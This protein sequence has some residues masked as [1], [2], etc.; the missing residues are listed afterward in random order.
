MSHAQRRLWFLEHVG[1]GGTAYHLAAGVRLTGPLNVPALDTALADV[2]ERH[3]PLRTV[4][5]DEPGQEILE[6]FR[7]EL[8]VTSVSESRLDAAVRAATAAPFRIDERPPFRAALFRLGPEEH[9]LVLM[10]HH[11]AVDGWSVPILMRDLGTAYR[12]R[13]V[14]L[15]GPGWDELPVRY[16]DYTLWQRDL[17]G[18]PADP[19]SL[20][21]RQ[22]D[23]WRR[24]LAGL[25]DAPAL[26]TDR[27]RPATAR[28]HGARTPVTCDPERYRDLVRLA[29]EHHCTPFMAVHALLAVLLSRLGASDDTVLGAAV[30]GRTEEPMAD[31]VG[32]FV[33]TLVLRTNLSD[34][35]SFRQVLDRVRQTDLDAYAHQD[36]PFDL[37]VEAL[38]PSRSLAHHPLF[39]VLLAFES[40]GPEQPDFGVVRAARLPVDGPPAAKVDLTFQLVEEQAEDGTPLHLTGY[41]EYD[42]DLFEADTA[43]AIPARLD[44]LLGAVVTDPDRPVAEIDLRTPQER[45]L[46]T[47]AD[48]PRRPVTTLPQSLAD[49]AA[50]TPDAPA[51]VC[52]DTTLTHAD[53]HTR[54]DRLAHRLTASGAAPG[55]IVAVALPRSVDFVV[56]ILAVLKAGCAYLPVD[57]ELPTARVDDMLAEA[58]P[59]CVLT[60]DGML[61]WDSDQGAAS[62]PRPEHPAYVI[63][64]SGSTGRPKGVVVSHAAIDNRLRWM[65]DA[66]PLRPG[67]RV[68]H[69]TPAG[70]DVS[71]WEL[72]WP[73][74]E[75][76]VLVVAGPDEHRD[77]AQLARTIRE[78]YVTI[79]HFVPSVL[80]LFLTEPEAA[81]CTG[82]RRVF[83]SGEALPAETARRFHATLPEVSLVNLYGPTEAAVDVTHHPCRPGD[84]GPVP[85]GLPVANTRTYVLDTCLRPCPPGVPGELYLAGAQ[86]ADGYLH[87][88]ALTA[89]RFVA[90]PYGPPGA[91]MYRT[92]DIVR[93]RRDGVLYY[94]GRDDQQV[95]FHG[96][97][98]ELG[99]IES[100]LRADDTV[101]TCCAVLRVADDGEQRLI[102]YVTPAQGK[103]LPPDPDELRRRL[104][105]RLPEAAVPGAVVVLDRLPLTPNGKLDRAALPLPAPPIRAAG[106]DSA[107]RTPQEKAVARAFADVLGLPSLDRDSDFF[108]SGGHSLLAVRLARRLR[109]EFG[110]DVPVQAV[111]RRPM[112]AA[113]AADLE[114]TSD[115]TEPL[116][117]LRSRGTGAPLFFVHP[118][119]GLSWCYHRLLD[120]LDTARPAYALQ[121]IGV[122]ELPG[123][124]E[125]MADDYIRRIREIQPEGPYHLLGWSL[126]GQIAH[127]MAVR[128]RRA[129]Q[130]VDLLA[131]FD[132]YAT[133]D[134]ADEEELARQALHNLC[135]GRAPAAVLD[136]ATMAEVRAHVPLLADAEPERV[137]AVLRA[138]RNNLRLAQRFVPDRF[139]GDLIL[140]TAREAAPADLGWARFVTGRVTVVP[141]D[142]GHYDM[143]TTAVEKVGRSLVPF[144]AAPASPEE[145]S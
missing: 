137:R 49:Q 59:V 15:A 32:F 104:A 65:Q 124:V 92:G 98:L 115:G 51:V 53:L 125:E 66:Y 103:Q 62:G 118:G 105:Q 13:A 91:R 132:S 112:V 39:Q 43:D 122:S 35:P 38:N 143:F 46:I 110:T 145:S 102:A 116:L 52:G 16:S 79:A 61:A 84:D 109:Q 131:L 55:G 47:T 56:A 129:G 8:T 76:A 28:H 107:P 22:T 24:A 140:L 93:Q 128:L 126:G 48:S 77:P 7:P 96:R 80:D 88:P 45:K 101:G 14:G 41:L 82:L 63:H 81:G 138:G 89:S 34:D 70:F 31:L 144:L 67:D 87:R 44:Q 127:A 57:P 12:Q 19:L 6:G 75:G 95:K 37:L 83:A 29:R 4:F 10:A 119:T 97:R 9:V 40:H 113:L 5:T 25:P 60:E 120:H 58:R 50:R 73:L 17:L 20:R 134:P 130:R 90:D 121:A 94:L 30:S 142:C 139:D 71:V 86:L 141:V 99:E 36:L 54:A 117:T 3:E 74:R 123:S 78:Q 27:P 18:D 23:F 106:T 100:L 2:A 1:A 111:F 108:A 136:D 11:I 85:I 64:T 133:S 72:F 135:D 68:L 21:S 33:N 26:P 42:T 69:K 114:V